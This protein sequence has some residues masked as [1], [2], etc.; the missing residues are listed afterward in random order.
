[1]S[2]KL[3]LKLKSILSKS[4]KVST[5]LTLKLNLIDKEAIKELPDF[6]KEVYL[7]K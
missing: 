5:K 7:T 3:T 6:V 2:L 1:L 4:N